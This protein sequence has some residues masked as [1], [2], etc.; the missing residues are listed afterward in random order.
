MDHVLVPLDD[1]EPARAALE[2][3]CQSY[4]DA[5]ITVVH[6][7][8]PTDT[9]LYTELTGGLRSTTESDYREATEELFREAR[10]IATGYDRTIETD[11]RVGK[12]GKEIVRAAENLEVDHI[13]VG[14]HGRSMTSR[15]LLG[16]VAEYVVRRAPVSVTVIR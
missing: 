8:D 6:V 5:E 15:V 13:V 11:Q 4:Q 9:H 14:S 10:T 16:S 1:F 2:H 7:A 3:T 12:P